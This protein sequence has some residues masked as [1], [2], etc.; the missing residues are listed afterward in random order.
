VGG[1]G[2][3]KLDNKGRSRNILTRAQR[4][5]FEQQLT[6]PEM[7]REAEK[8]IA[9]YVLD[10]LGTEIE[11]VLVTYPTSVSSVQ[12]LLGLGDTDEGTNILEMPRTPSAPKAPSIRSTKRRTDQNTRDRDDSA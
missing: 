2:F 12:W 4:N 11:R 8:L 3:K 7:P 5:W 9:G 10:E 6:L 1:R